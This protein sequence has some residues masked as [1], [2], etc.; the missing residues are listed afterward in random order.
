MV[1]ASRPIAIRDLGARA[2]IERIREVVRR[3]GGRAVSRD[4]VEL[5]RVTPGELAAEAAAHGLRAQAPGRIPPATRT[6][7]R[8]W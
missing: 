8:R 7:A 4:V 5:D 6:S 3:D 1:Y 2:A